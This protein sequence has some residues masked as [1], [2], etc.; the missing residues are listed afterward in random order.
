LYVG[1]KYLCDLSEVSQ[2]EKNDA[3]DNPLVTL[4]GKIV[5][6]VI[7]SY[8]TDVLTAYER[9]SSIQPLEKTMKNAMMKYNKHKMS[10]S[11]ASVRKSKELGVVGIHPMV[12]SRVCT[13]DKVLMDLQQEIKT[14][15]PKLNAIECMYTRY[16]QTEDL[17]RLQGIIKAQNKELSRK[18]EMEMVRKMAQQKIDEAEQIQHEEA[19]A[20]DEKN[21]TKQIKEPQEEIEH[22]VNMSKHD[23]KHLKRVRVPH[24]HYS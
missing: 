8:N 16:K 1:R 13:E 18:E 10:A 12:M 21:S 2:E 23:R 3:F 20:I 11:T 19:K 5:Q 24:Y 14:F 9:N 17:E 15:K 7:D 22:K 6:K 4:Y